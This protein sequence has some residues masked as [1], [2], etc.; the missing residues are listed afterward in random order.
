MRAVLRSRELMSAVIAYAAAITASNLIPL[1]VGA[2]AARQHLDDEQIGMVAM[3]EAMALALTTVFATA[4]PLRIGR[5]AGIAGPVGVVAGQLASL[6]VPGLY[7]LA[8]VRGLVGVGCGLAGAIVSRSIAASMHAAPAFGLANGV[9]AMMIGS[10][11]AAIPWFPS[12]DAGM[13][14][15]VSLALLGA[16]LAGTAWVAMR[17][18]PGRRGTGGAQQEPAPR[19]MRLPALALC[20]ATL[21]IYVP[22]GGIWTFSVQLGVGLGLTERHVGALLIFAVFGGL[23]GGALAAWLESRTDLGRLL[24]LGPLA[25]IASCVAVGATRGAWSFAAAFCLYSAAYQFAISVLQVAGALADAR[26]RLPAILLG[27]TLVGYAIGSWLV[28][29]LLEVGR[30]ALIWTGG[31]WACALAIAPSL[32]A[33]RR[34]RLT[35]R[36]RPG[37]TAPAAG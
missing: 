12:P 20:A 21:L 36:T 34:I 35:S 17:E 13:R 18:L 14:I 32:L 37:P 15:F 9:S 23:L 22:L 24:L 6:W 4:L 10:L 28:G 5:A 8:V 11:L 29:H 7:G 25:C 19:M 26:C 16:L 1:Q 3:C 2:F 27:M 31:S 30:P 33:L